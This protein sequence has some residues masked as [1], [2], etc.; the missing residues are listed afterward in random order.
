MILGHFLFWVTFYYW[1]LLILGHFLF[2]WVGFLT[3]CDLRLV[4]GFLDFLVK[5]FSFENFES[6]FGIRMG[7]F[8]GVN[9]LHFVI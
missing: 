5:F 7:I 4:L 8:G 9:F 3:F 2:W 1:S 6:C